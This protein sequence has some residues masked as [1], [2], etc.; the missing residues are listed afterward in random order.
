MYVATFK[1]LVQAAGT[2]DEAVMSSTW[3][4]GNKIQQMHVGITHSLNVGVYTFS[5]DKCLFIFCWQFYWNVGAINSPYDIW[6]AS[7]GTESLVQRKR[8]GSVGQ[9][10]QCVCVSTDDSADVGL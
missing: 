8:D 4:L 1:Q 6:K 9:L 5:V 3:P 10:A 2:S 7:N